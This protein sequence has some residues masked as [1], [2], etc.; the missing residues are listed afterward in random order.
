MLDVGILGVGVLFP[1]QWKL[2]SKSSEG[3]LEAPK[4]GLQ[5][6]PENIQKAI[7]NGHL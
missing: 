4:T 2:R 1:R 7:E 5:I 3:S 6:P